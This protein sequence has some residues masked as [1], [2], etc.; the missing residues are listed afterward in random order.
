MPQGREQA[1]STRRA[2]LP[3]ESPAPRT[4]AL[5]HKLG[6]T[7]SSTA[8]SGAPRAYG[9][10]DRCDTQ[11]CKA[12]RAARPR[13]GADHEVE[14]GHRDRGEIRAKYGIN[15]RSPPPLRAPRRRPHQCRGFSSRRDAISA[16]GRGPRKPPDVVKRLQDSRRRPEFRRLEKAYAI[17]AARVRIMSTRNRRRRPRTSPRRGA[18]IRHQ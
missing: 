3:S 6:R 16:D 14:G 7:S 11:V 12:G 10:G 4:A 9:L 13:Q 15:P 18:E 5:S 1:L 8:S 17:Q 2:R